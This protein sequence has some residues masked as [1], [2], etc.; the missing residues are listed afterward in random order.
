MKTVKLTSPLRGTRGAVNAFTFR[1]PKFE[2]FMTLGD[3]RVPIRSGDSF[4][5]QPVPSLIKNYAERLLTGEGDAGD[6]NIMAGAS[7]Q[8]S[9]A[10]ERTVL[11][12]FMDLETPTKSADSAASSS[13]APTK[14]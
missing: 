8:D 11:S 7:L 1:E 12:F 2:D 6:V 13:T 9:R 14:T 5:W 4:F 3:P 10:I